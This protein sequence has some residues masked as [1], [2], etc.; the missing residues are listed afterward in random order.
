MPYIKKFKK[1]KQIRTVQEAVRRILK[2]EFIF[3][4]HKAYHCGWTCGWPLH[5]IKSNAEF[6]HLFTAIK[7]KNGG[8]NG[9]VRTN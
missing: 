1:G 9:K 4:R 3:Y 2:G 6:G 8:Y 5:S 7:V